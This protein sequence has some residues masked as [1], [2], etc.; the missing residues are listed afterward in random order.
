MTDID[1][2]RL[3]AELGLKAPH[4]ENELAVGCVI[5]DQAGN[6]VATGFERRTV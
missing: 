3:A 2:M 5:A 6:V 1:L 4:T